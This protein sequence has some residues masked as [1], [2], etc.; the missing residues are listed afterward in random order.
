M[1]EKVCVSELFSKENCGKVIKVGTSAVLVKFMSPILDISA[2][3]EVERF[4]NESSTRTLS[5]GRYIG[6]GI[7]GTLVGLGI[8]H[9]MQGRYK[10]S[11]VIFTVGEGVG[12][13]LA[14]GCS[15]IALLKSDDSRRT[16]D[17]HHDDFP[18]VCLVSLGIAGAIHLWEIEDV[19]VGGARLLESS[20][21]S[22]EQ[23]S[24][25]HW[26]LFPTLVTRN[27]PGL[28]AV[29]PF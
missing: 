10:P 12:Y 6:S 7:V 5:K 15:L 16:S 3:M 24:G 4:A 23:S 19:W 1:G 17:G 8:G 27:A 11:G 18:N 20:S 28:G 13:G 26:S 22:G 2:G 14:L 21:V 29:I 9:K 25:L